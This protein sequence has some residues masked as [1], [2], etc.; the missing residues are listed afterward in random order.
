MLKLIK[1]QIRTECNYEKKTITCSKSQT[2]ISNCETVTKNF[3][4]E[5]IPTILTRTPKRQSTSVLITE[6]RTEIFT[7]ELGRGRSDL[8]EVE[9]MLDR[10]TSLCRRKRAIQ[11]F[12]SLISLSQIT[13]FVV[14]VLPSHLSIKVWPM[15]MAVLIVN[16]PWKFTALRLQIGYVYKR[17]WIWYYS[18]LHTPAPHSHE[19]TTP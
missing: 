17:G 7:L 11:I 15:E 8:Y 9:S 2:R 6:V 18:H 10:V 1:N 19:N 5:K 14:V 16:S 3:N 13:K 12:T 4:L